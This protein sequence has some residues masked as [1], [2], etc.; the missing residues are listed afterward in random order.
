MRLN[1][2]NMFQ[3]IIAGGSTDTE[4]TEQLGSALTR[5][6]NK[7]SEFCRAMEILIMISCS[8]A[9]GYRRFG[10]TCCPHLQGAI[11][12]RMYKADDKIIMPL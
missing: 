12:H 9:G 3:N 2:S 7:G 11:S 10:G 6:N 5:M 4:F 1:G 8:I